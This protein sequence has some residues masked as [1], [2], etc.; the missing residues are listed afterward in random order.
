MEFLKAAPEQLAKYTDFLLTFSRSPTQALEPFAPQDLATG[1]SVS[2]Q[3]LLYTALSVGLAMLM[4][5]VGRGVGM[6]PD[7]SVIVGKVGRIEEKWLPLA[8]VAL[9]VIVAVGWHSLA[10]GVGWLLAR[11]S[12]TPAFRGGVA[13]SINALLALAAWYLPLFMGVLILVRVAALRS[14]IPP[15][16]F[17][18]P[19]IPLGLLFPVYFVLAFAA[20]HRL[21]LSHAAYLFGC[22]VTI[23][24]VLIN[25]MV[26]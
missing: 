2:S 20:I 10:K 15:L 8:A 24:T 18:I 13:G 9:V 26:G 17:L 1:Q 7:T 12:T 11:V 23:L 14:Q 22:T 4:N 3:L 25:L 5:T 6:A 16:L 21:S 19:V